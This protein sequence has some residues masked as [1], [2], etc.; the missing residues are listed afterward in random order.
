MSDDAE[1]LRLSHA[2]RDAFQLARPGD[3]ASRFV[4]RVVTTSGA[5][6]KYIK[7]RPQLAMGTEAENAVPVFYDLGATDVPVLHIGPA[8]VAAGDRVIVRSVADRW[9]SRRRSGGGGSLRGVLLGCVCA[10]PPKTLTMTVASCTDGRFNP[11]TIE[12]GPTPSSLSALQLGANCYLSTTSFADPQTGDHFYYFLSCF[13]SVVRLSRVFPTSIFGSP[14]L[15]SIIYYW[16]LGFPG[17]TCTPTF[18][19]TNGTVF[20]GGDPACVVQITG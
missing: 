12:Y 17:N 19:L 5:A 1:R 16:S 10:T 11:C 8:A 13:A 4:G 15:D 6:D 3:G 9:V 14:F 20:A 18:A 2:G 7:V